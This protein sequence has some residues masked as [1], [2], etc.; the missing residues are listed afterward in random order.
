MAAGR[1]KVLLE[2]AGKPLLVHA[3][4]AFRACCDSL[5]VV[6]AKAD[7][8]EIRALLPDVLVAPGGSSRHGSEW[9]GLQ[10]F[11]HAVGPDDVIAIHD[12]ARP[13]VALPD[14]LAVF[15]EAGRHGAA[16]LAEPALAPAL[17]VRGDRIVG[18]YHASQLWRAQTPQAARAGLLLSAYRR[19][20]SEGFTGTDTAAVLAWAGIA[21]RIVAASASN[22]KITVPSDLAAAQASLR[23]T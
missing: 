13:L 14:V 12:A 3:V 9:N 2:L 4:E 6:A 11:Q 8:P 17:E 21:V 20:D 1:N 22:P 10:A 18:G 5:I 23:E 15:A 16:M 19:A 7:L